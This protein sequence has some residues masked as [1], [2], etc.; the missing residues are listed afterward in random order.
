MVCAL[1]CGPP[2]LVAPV[3]HE[4]TM[5]GWFFAVLGVELEKAPPLPGTDFPDC[6]IKDWVSRILGVHWP[7]VYLVSRRV[8]ILGDQGEAPVMA[9]KKPLIHNGM[10]G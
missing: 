7:K 9:G 3:H 1:P 4:K 5:C 8:E 6:T 10:G 2:A